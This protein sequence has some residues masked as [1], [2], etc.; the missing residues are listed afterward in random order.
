MYLKHCVF[1]FQD[2][3]EDEVCMLMSTEIEEIVYTDELVCTHKN[4]ESCHSTFK[5]VLRK[6][7]VSWQNQLKCELHIQFYDIFFQV[8][9]CE[10]DYIKECHIDYEVRL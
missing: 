6:S 4:F 8:E 10:T 9:K 3:E 5:S 2:L 7:M 1:Q